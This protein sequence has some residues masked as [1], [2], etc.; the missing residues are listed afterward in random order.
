MSDILQTI[1]ARKAEE[2]AQRR[3]QRPL[4]ELQATDAARAL[5]L[6][7][8]RRFTVVGERR[9]VAPAVTALR[10]HVFEILEEEIARASA[11]G[12]DGR[13]EQALRHLVGRLLHVPTARAHELAESGR[14]TDYLEALDALFGIRPAAEQPVTGPAAEDLAG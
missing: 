8:A 14:A 5:V 9:A 10:G 7:A 2:V 1:L 3:A 12:D 11:K 13:T 4:E 6:D